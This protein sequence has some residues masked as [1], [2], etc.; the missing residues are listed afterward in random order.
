MP[1]ILKLHNV[2][3]KNM[4]EQCDAECNHF[5]LFD[6]NIDHRKD[7]RAVAYKDRFETINGHKVLPK[8][9]AGWQLCYK[10]RDGITLWEALQI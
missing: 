4:Y 5:V 6:A 7:E 1:L 9:T 3:A 2:I 8:T 10:W